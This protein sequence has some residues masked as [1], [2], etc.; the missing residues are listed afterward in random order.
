MRLPFSKLPRGFFW[1]SLEVKS[2][3]SVSFPNTKPRRK[4]RMPRYTLDRHL[5]DDMGNILGKLD[6]CGEEGWYW[7]SFD[8]ALGYADTEGE[9][10]HEL[11][12]Y[13]GIDWPIR[14]VCDS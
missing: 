6:D 10:L 9:A 12:S 7:E 8:G 13:L 1:F 3:L 11:F 5:M 14:H 4:K 2:H